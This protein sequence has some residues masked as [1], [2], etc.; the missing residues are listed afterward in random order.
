[1]KKSLSILMAAG[2]I[3]YPF[4]AFS[5][6][7]GS[8]TSQPQQQAPPVAQ[9]LVREGD[10]A[11]R[12]AAQL[13]LGN[14]ADEAS[15]EDVLTVAGVVP[16]NGWISDYPVTPQIMGQLQTA[17]ARSASEKKIPLTAEEAIKGLYY[18]AVQMNLPVPANA[19]SPS[20][21]AGSSAVQLP[22]E[23]PNPTIVNEYYYDAGPPIVTYYPPPSDYLYLYDWVPY[24]AWWAGFWFPGFYICHNFTTTI[25]VTNG[26]F[27][28]GPFVPRRAIVSNHF[29]DRVSGRVAVV[30]PVTRAGDGRI[31]PVTMLRTEGGSL[32]RTVHD[33]RNGPDAREGGMRTRGETV[34][35][36]Q[37]GGF[38]SAAARNSA[39][40][41]Y[42]RSAARDS[43]LLTSRNQ[44]M[45]PRRQ[46]GET[47]RFTP[48]NTRSSR[49]F[50][51][52]APWLRTA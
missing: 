7:Y 33:M 16:D 24:P 15:A 11:I 8:P 50:P 29:I 4:A 26:P 45:G 17:I 1:M 40:S 12:L 9:T 22:T 32:F 48:G 3:M 38:A 37:S 36:F 14:P 5:E 31:R 23:A 42:S 47:P 19:V 10:F 41:I 44:A 39:S 25:V 2:L 18:L 34:R 35:G 13:D 21:E 6:D 49:G 43:E 46:I 20:Q 51:P 30:T 28:H 27:I 52:A